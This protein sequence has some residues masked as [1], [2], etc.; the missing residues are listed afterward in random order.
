MSF[1]S[2]QGQCLPKTGGTAVCCCL[3]MLYFLPWITWPAAEWTSWPLVCAAK[4]ETLK[5]DWKSPLLLIHFLHKG[6]QHLF[7][8]RRGI[9]GGHDP[10]PKLMS[11]KE[12]SADNSYDVMPLHLRAG[13]YH[14]LHILISSQKQ[15]PSGI[16]TVNTASVS[17]TCCSSVQWES[18]WAAS[19]YYLKSAQHQCCRD[20]E[21]FISASEKQQYLL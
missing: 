5:T 13:S 1:I 14:S 12:F 19:L 3:Q 7:H 6:L 11:L 18:R 2:Q 9:W 16:W 17:G 10:M 20:E 8:G 4:S 21:H 15:L